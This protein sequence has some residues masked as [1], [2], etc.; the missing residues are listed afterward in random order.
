M[1]IPRQILVPTDFSEPAQRAKA[2]A[3]VLAESFRAQLHLLH[4]IPDPLDMGWGV[5][6]AHLP[7]LLER[8]ERNVRA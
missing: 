4:V 7:Q 3:L 1:R 5:D 8:T 6:A 2:Y